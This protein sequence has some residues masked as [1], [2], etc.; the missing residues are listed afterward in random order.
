MDDLVQS[1]VC[2]NPRPLLFHGYLAPFF[3]L[4]AFVYYYFSFD[5]TSVDPSDPTKD[6]SSEA[7]KR[8]N[9]I[10]VIAV[11]VSVAIQ[12]IAY[13]F[14][15]WSVDVKCWLS[16]SRSNDPHSSKFVKVTPT[17]NNGA[18]EL[19][20]L[21]KETIAK[22]TTLGFMFQ[23]AKYVLDEKSNKFVPVEF[24]CDRKISYYKQWK[25]YTDPNEMQLIERQYGRN[26]L[27]MAIPEF[28]ELFIEKATAPFFVFQTFCVGLW[29]L[30]EFWYYALF[31]LFMLVTFEVVLVKNQLR[32]MQEIRRMGN[33]PFTI[34]VFRQN[35][36]KPIKS[37]QLVPGDLVSI[38]RSDHNMPC[39]ILLLRGS[40]IIDEST[41]TGESVPQTKE[42]LEDVDD[43]DRKLDIDQDKLHILF[44]GT[45][46]LQHTAPSKEPGC[47]GYV[48]RTGFHTS[49]GK[50][51]RTILFGVKRVTANN[52]ETF[53]FI[54]FLLVFAII[55]AY[56]V[57][58]NGIKDPNRSR[59]RLFFECTVIITSVV[60]PE[61]PIELSLAVNTSLL[62]LSKLYIY[63]T[64]PFRIPFAGKVEYC[65]FDKTGTLTSDDLIV[66]GVAG[67]PKPTENQMK[68]ENEPLEEKTPVIH[69]NNTIK[70]AI[71]D[72]DMVIPIEQ[73]P[74]STLQ[75]LASCHSLAHLDEKLVGDPLEKKVLEAINWN[76]SKSGAAT[77][78]K[79]RSPPLK[80][81]QRFHFNSTLKRMS[82]VASYK[83]DM[84]NDNI[85]ICTAKGAPEFM[86]PLMKNLPDN[87]DEV[88]LQMSR[89]GARVLTLGYK[90][91]GQL[92]HQELTELKREDVENGLM[93]AGFLLISCPLKPDSKAVSLELA[94]SGHRLVMITGD[95]ALTA[96]HVGS[97]LSFTKRDVLI[98]TKSRDSE[99]DMNC[100]DWK[101]VSTDQKTSIPFADTLEEFLRVSRQ[102]DLCMTGDALGFILRGQK[103]KLAYEI[104]RRV[105]IFARVSPKQKESIITTLKS[106]GQTVL[107]CGDGTNDV[108]AL[109]HA[110]VGVALLSSSPITKQPAK[111]VGP[112]SA[113]EEALKQQQQLLSNGIKQ[114]AAK[115]ATQNS[116]RKVGQ[117]NVQQA[118]KLMTPEER[119]LEKM[120]EAQ[121][122][123]KQLLE[124]QD[125]IQY[126]K[127]GDASIAAP[128]TSRLSST[129][130]ISHIIK[131][132]RC[133]LVTTLQMFKILALNALLSAYCHSVLYLD[134]I[135]FSDGQFTVQGIL[136]TLCFLFITRS[137]PL[138][139]LSAQRP[140]PNIFNLYTILTVTLQF[141]VHFSSL[142]FLYTQAKTF[143]GVLDDR[144]ATL[145]LDDGNL[146]TM[147]P[148]IDVL[149]DSQQN[150]TAS[151][152]DSTISSLHTEF[153]ATLV[154]ST[155]Y[156][157]WL[158][159]QIATFVVNYKGHPFMQNL[160]SN[161]PLCYSF[162][163]AVFLIF[164]C[165][166][167]WSPSLAEQLS[168]VEFPNEFRPIVLTTIVTN[169]AMAYAIDRICDYLFGRLK[170]KAL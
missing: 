58:T 12:I 64:E 100:D 140:L 143:Q 49:Q 99:K 88:Y 77:P 28:K 53:C 155:I 11:M 65:C 108:G 32:N 3:V 127:L 30:D 18:T 141:A 8:H 101:W 68:E 129:Q 112:Q 144:N 130:C 60:P 63:C 15:H 22:Q 55:S 69:S 42:P 123:L 106:R 31:T 149:S 43:D 104:I 66:E 167:G 96:C 97:L 37:D 93:F 146:T 27:D 7:S 35:K 135:K 5:E 48:L 134:G 85:Y 23:K 126:V 78:K 159:I 154:N 81:H 74:H 121:A 119:R 62:S 50:L 94:E 76:F 133:T 84:S 71:V 59:Y 153:K 169:F 131:Q 79:G 162:V 107:M 67:L 170:L 1:V 14:C 57:W 114:Q 136:S 2:Y 145:G 147:S 86:K 148:V 113:I 166:N 92:S 10:W 156:V 164:T 117:S 98:L 163:G 111:K 25:G 102:Y 116:G 90:T 33:Q 19:V 46:I 26:E 82:V 41:L 158:S 161:R 38:V 56:Y 142:V 91:L 29:C 21:R 61:L 20:P 157:I 125:R 165:V 128:F 17:P 103:E 168:L 4:Q 44:G 124:E 13:L 9:E 138:T 132:G 39:D 87:Y 89:L 110:N 122:K 16:Y 45:K 54:M 118:N 24:A 152:T 34:Q 70:S 51:L 150:M 137:Q 83:I 105:K 151:T 52:F 160:R 75:V 47:I 115:L 80:I 95:G 72:N 109:K 36:W 120:M 139:K 6:I 40:C 73:C